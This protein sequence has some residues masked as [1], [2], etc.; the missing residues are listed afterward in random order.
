MPGRSATA[1]LLGREK[2]QAELYDALSLA[3]EGEPQVV[4]VAGDAGVGKTT[5]VADL[6]R[7]AGDLGFTVATGHGLDIAE[8]RPFF[9]DQ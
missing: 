6:A 3:L 7:R 5:I 1:A 9:V 8:A 4:V 2:E